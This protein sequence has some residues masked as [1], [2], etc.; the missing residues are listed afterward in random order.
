M[1][2]G[3]TENYPAMIQ[4]SHYSVIVPFH[5]NERLLRFCLKTLLTTVPPDVEK[6]VVLNN[7]RAEEL[8]A[9]INTSHFR[10]IRHDESLGYSH[11]VNAG[12]SVARGQTLIF[13]DADTFYAG[14]WF[15][16]LTHFHRNTPN[17]GLASSRL[18][19]P[20][21][22]R[23]LDFG[24][25]FT[26]YNAPHPQRDVLADH[27]SVARPRLVQAACSANMIIEADLFSR[28][29]M[30]DEELH[31]AYMDLD[32][33]LRL[34]GLGR[35]CWVV[36]QS[37][38]FH[39]GDSA[40]THRG[41]YWADVKA[42]FASKNAGR[43]EQDMHRYFRESLTSFQSS[44]GFASGYLLI[45]LSSVIDRAWH[46][47]LLR[48]YVELISVYDYSPVARDLPLVSLIDH[49]GVN[50]LE[51]RR[52]LLYFVDRFISLQGNRM[53][54]DM[55]RRSDDLVIDR[56]ANVALLSEVVNGIR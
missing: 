43:I 21:T 38:A 2:I 44:H 32:L 17:L 55:R 19:D 9:D 10:V 6:I 30:F 47:D 13:C 52:A 11:A 18:L 51:S 23:V 27:P 1:W 56:N 49:L 7:H 33:C 45:D 20:R 53:W 25:A 41:A 54:L 29:G 46:Y 28:V 12:A 39:R 24:I 5:S 8:P 42:M 15:S 26:K 37:T 3:I 35:D 4:S 31:N 34:K 50:V 14:N 36:S 40:R 48:E 16:A 22:G